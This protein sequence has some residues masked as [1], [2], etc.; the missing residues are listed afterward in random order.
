VN[1]EDQNDDDLIIYKD[2]SLR[3]RIEHKEDLT[4]SVPSNPAPSAKSKPSSTL[5]SKAEAAKKMMDDHKSN[6]TQL[7]CLEIDGRTP[8]SKADWGAFSQIIN[9]VKGL[10]FF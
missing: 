7:N 1:E 5:P 6:T 3:K 10:G 8:L 9:E 4:E 2:F